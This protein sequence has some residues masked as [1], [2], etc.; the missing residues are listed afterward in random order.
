MQR[1]IEDKLTNL[2]KEKQN[3]K[4]EIDRIT[5]ELLK[6]IP[7]A[8]FPPHLVGCSFPLKQLI[9]CFLFAS[10]PKKL[11]IS[12]AQKLISWRKGSMKLLTE[13]TETLVDL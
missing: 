12:G 8:G 7:Y 6:V 4:E 2:K 13:S 9:H 10:S 5:P 3:I 11:L 1:S